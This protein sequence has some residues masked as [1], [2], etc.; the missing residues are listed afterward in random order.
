MPKREKANSEF[1][2]LR[3]QANPTSAER[4]SV[5]SYWS[6][7]VSVIQAKIC[8]YHEDK[9]VQVDKPWTYDVQFLISDSADLE[10]EDIPFNKDSADI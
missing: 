2:V 6:R 8:H 3:L 7:V 1:I 5:G 9:W 4:A 10:Q